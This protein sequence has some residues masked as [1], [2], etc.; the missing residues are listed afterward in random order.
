MPSKDSEACA[1]G[2]SGLRLRKL[3]KKRPSLDG[4][5]VRDSERGESESAMLAAL[6]NGDGGKALRTDFSFR[7]DHLDAS[8]SSS[9]ESRCLIKRRQNATITTVPMTVCSR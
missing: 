4:L 6:P 7:A 3:A 9:G 8:E 5:H 2:V 1:V